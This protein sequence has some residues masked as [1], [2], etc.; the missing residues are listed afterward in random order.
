MECRDSMR[1]L[2]TLNPEWPERDSR[3]TSAVRVRVPGPNMEPTAQQSGA[4]CFKRHKGSKRRAALFR[5]LR[6]STANQTSDVKQQ[7]FGN[8]YIAQGLR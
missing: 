3:E 5:Q 4:I 2:A 6:A 8:A 7:T 1:V